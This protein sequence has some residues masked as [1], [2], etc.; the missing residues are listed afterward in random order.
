M[1]TPCRKPEQA[2]AK[3]KTLVI[4]NEADGYWSPRKVAWQIAGTHHFKSVW[5][6]GLDA[7][8]NALRKYRY[9][10]TE[11]DNSAECPIYAVKIADDFKSWTVERVQ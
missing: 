10:V 4:F 7:V 1:S 3:G 11:L 9:E 2:Y 5:V 6:V 8:Y